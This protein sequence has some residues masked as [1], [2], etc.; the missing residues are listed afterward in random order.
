M[1]T[2]LVDADACPVKDEIYK[3]ALRHG[4][5]VVVVSNSPIRVPAHPAIRRVVVPDAF[6][7]AD[8]WIAEAATPRSV[9]VTN[10]ILLADRA[11]KAGA[12][13]LAPTGKPFEAAGIGAA[14]ATRAIMADLR[15]GMDG[16]TGGPP[17]FSKADRSNFLQALDRVLAALARAN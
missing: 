7:A 16:I 10:D 2:V 6:D 9:V 8:D 13:V 3:V 1:F 14:I 4:A 12:K 11:I 15:A 17:P 5:A